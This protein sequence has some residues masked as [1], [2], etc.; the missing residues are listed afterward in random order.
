MLAPLW[1]AWADVAAAHALAMV[2]Q[3]TAGKSVA[4]AYRAACL[5]LMMAKGDRSSPHF[6]AVFALVG[7]PF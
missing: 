1:E 4:Y 2:R 6:W 3:L 5:E 7:Y